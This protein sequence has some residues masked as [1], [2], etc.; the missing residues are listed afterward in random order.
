MTIERLNWQHNG[1]L[2]CSDGHYVKFEHYER[3]IA[4]LRKRVADFERYKMQHDYLH[5]ECTRI[6]SEHHLPIKDW[7]EMSDMEQ[8]RWVIMRMDEALS[9]VAAQPAD[10]STRVRTFRNEMPKEGQV[11]EWM[12]KDWRTDR[13]V[14]C[15]FYSDRG[16]YPHVKIGPSNFYWRPVTLPYSVEERVEIERAA[17][18]DERRKVLAEVRNYMEQ[19]MQRGKVISNR[20]PTSGMPSF[21]TIPGANGTAVSVPSDMPKPPSGEPIIPVAGQDENLWPEFLRLLAKTPN[22]TTH[23]T[24]SGEDPAAGQPQPP[25]PIAT[26]EAGEPKQTLN[27]IELLVDDDDE[28]EI[29]KFVDAFNE[30]DLPD[31]YADGANKA[32]RVIGE[33]VR[34]VEEYRGWHKALPDDTAKLRKWCDRM[35]QA[36]LMVLDAQRGPGEVVFLSDGLRTL[37]RSHGAK[38]AMIIGHT[39][40]D[41]VIGDNPPFRGLLIRKWLKDNRDKPIDR[42]VVVDDD[43]DGITECK[44]PFVRT[45]GNKGLTVEAANEVIR[46]LNRE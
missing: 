28:R 29:R 19:L 44:L 10:V 4:E 20:S 17:R 45:D 13:W 5:E 11:I 32:G 3:E 1:M 15:R 23:T 7:S 42:Y 24:P 18:E 16:I 33:A 14:A 21:T 30:D 8:V 9:A 38:G 41:E 26:D 37:L 6:F 39:D 40:A 31:A 36:I 2:I 27:R 22:C 46:I 43:N 25:N 35:K 34:I 12:H